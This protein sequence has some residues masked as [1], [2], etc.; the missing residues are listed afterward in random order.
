MLTRY[1]VKACHPLDP[2]ANNRIE[3]QLQMYLRAKPFFTGA[4][5]LARATKKPS[6]WAETRVR[7]ADEVS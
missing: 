2:W 7:P 5:R 3:A 6:T 1:R 4:R